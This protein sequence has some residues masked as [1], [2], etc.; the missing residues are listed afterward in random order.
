MPVET[1]SCPNCGA[2]LR[3]SKENHPWFCVYCNSLIHV[4]PD[5]P[6]ASLDSVE[7]G[8][9][10]QL[11]ISGQRERAVERFQKIS[12]LGIP[13]AQEAIDQMAADFSIH[14][15]YHQQLT[16]GGIAIVSISLIV[17]LAALLGWGLGRLNPWLALLGVAFAGFLLLV[18]GRG[19]LTTLRYINAPIAPAATLHFTPIG[20]AQIGRKRLHTYLIVLEVRPKDAPPFQAQAVIPVRDENIDRVRQ[21]AVIQVKYLPGKPGSVIYHQA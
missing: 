18:Y 17:L 16:P 1:L 21:G 8:A 19:A 12:D 20:A 15:L 9:I 6:R 10:K 3:Q 7:M 2:P 13:E 14:T 5:A 4:Q 11:L